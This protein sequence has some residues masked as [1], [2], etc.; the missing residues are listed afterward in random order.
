MRGPARPT[1]AIK[2]AIRE[3]QGQELHGAA[4][5]YSEGAHSA[6]SPASERVEGSVPHPAEKPGNGPRD[7]R[8]ADEQEDHVAW[9]VLRPYKQ[10]N[11]DGV[12]GEEDADGLLTGAHRSSGPRPNPSHPIVVLPCWCSAL[13]LWAPLVWLIALHA[14]N[15]GCVMFV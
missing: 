3:Q 10:Q 11:A 13:S 14:A 6:S 4:A 7:G 2:V 1:V 5:R 8:D 9:H 12:Q 15:G